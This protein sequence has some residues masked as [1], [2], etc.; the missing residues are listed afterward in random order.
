M[1][2]KYLVNPIFTLF[3]VFFCFNAPA[4]ATMRVN[5]HLFPLAHYDQSVEH[6]LQQQP[7]KQDKSLLGDELQQTHFQQF[8]QHWLSPWQAEPVEAVLGQ[9]KPGLATLEREALKDFDNRGKSPEQ[10]HYGTNFRAYTG[11]WIKAISDNIDTATLT[12]TSFEPAKRGIA[13]RNALLRLLPTRDPGF[14]YFTYY[15]QG[16][17]FDHLQESVL[18]AG[19]PVYVVTYTRDHRWALVF[20]P[21]YTGWVEANTIAMADARFVKHWQ[22]AS[23]AGLAAITKTKTPLRDDTG[24]YYLSGN[25]GTVLPLAHPTEKDFHVFIPV[26]DLKGFANMVSV[27]A[28]PEHAVK[29]PWQATPK[30]FAILMKTLM[31]RPYGWGN[32]YF[33]NDC[34]SELKSLYAPFGIWLPRHSLQQTNVGFR[35]NQSAAPEEKRIAY[36]KKHGH[37]FMTIVYVSG[38]IFQFVGNIKGAPMTYQSMWGLG[39]RDSRDHK[40]I[41]QSVLLPLQHTYSEDLE[42]TSHATKKDFVVSFLDKAANQPLEVPS[43]RS[44]VIPEPYV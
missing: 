29:M 15:A 33:Y 11:A 27:I 30:H 6:F 9:Q 19:T 3:M 28:P 12:F 16:Y 31:G 41:G 36:L 44:K 35:V 20:T 4:A 24:Q 25:V 32:L 17:P 10:Q 5:I 23:K 22:E 1:T 14:H 37:A 26:R 18:W 42:V 2:V 40:I 43:L 8:K 38:H 7:L 13:V 39:V 34:S 21:T